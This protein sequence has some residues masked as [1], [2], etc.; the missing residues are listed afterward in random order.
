M[1]KFHAGALQLAPIRFLRI[2]FI[3]LFAHLYFGAARRLDLPNA[4]LYFGLNLIFIPLLSFSLS[5]PNL[6]EERTKIKP[7]AKRWD[8]LFN[9]IFSVLLFV[10]VI[11]AGL[12]EGRFHW[13]ENLV[14]AARLSTVILL[15]VSTFLLTWSMKVNTFFSRVVRI[16]RDR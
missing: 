10:M 3:S 12:D 5:D 1:L 7:D 8:L 16:Q 9:R 14:V 11:L 13:N 6:V 2:I 15:L 4:L